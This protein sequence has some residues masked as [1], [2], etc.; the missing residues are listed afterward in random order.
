M[1][2]DNNSGRVPNHTGTVGGIL[3]KVQQAWGPGPL[4]NAKLNGPVPDR[5]FLYPSYPRTADPQIAKNLT[6]GRLM[7]GS[8]VI[9]SPDGAAGLWGRLY[10]D[11]KL[12]SYLHGFEWLQSFAV[13][14]QELVL[15]GDDKALA[16]N[17]QTIRGLTTE[18]LDRNEKWSPEIW[19][20]R[21]IAE[22][23]LHLCSQGSLIL[24]DSD[25]MWRSR[26]LTSMAR[27]ARYLAQCANK[28]NPGIDALLTAM[29]LCLAGLCLPG[30]EVALER[31]QELV[32]RELRL[33]LRSDGGHISRNPSIQLEIVLRL[34]MIAECY[35]HRKLPLPGHVR[36]A[37]G[38]AAAMVEF[39][40][41]PDG[42][43]MVFNGGYEDDSKA[44]IAAS[45]QIQQDSHPLGFAQ[46]TQYQR[47]NA[48]RAILLADVGSN[49]AVSKADAQIGDAFESAGSFHFSSGRTRI[50]SN[51][52]NGDHLGGDWPKALR[53]AAAHSGLSFEGQT[54]NRLD[55][56]SGETTHQ[57]ME[58]VNGILL[59]ITRPFV[60]RG[61]GKRHPS[62]AY[63]NNQAA[64]NSALLVPGYTRR[65]YMSAGGDDFRGEDSMI[66]LPENLTGLWRIRFHLAPCV[67][68]SVAR[69]EQSVILAMDNQEGWR[70]RTNY[71]GVRLEKSVYC[72]LGGTP[73]TTEQIVIGP[74]I[75]SGAIPNKIGPDMGEPQNITIKWAFKRLDGI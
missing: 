9:D 54:L 15:Q 25:P 46:Y 68:A 62:Q 42:A 56:F 52:G 29:G 24:N 11:E 17:E 45:K 19:Q 37:L 51:C 58:E 32:R 47:I 10:L 59:E 66:G 57:R 69:D 72:G 5:L 70:F 55:L 65:L 6:S 73:Q 20:P 38:R 53:Q 8:S 2:S 4:Q 28:A 33:Q 23:L 75:A 7:I 1:K 31:G 43:L 21:L 40:R 61:G 60:V 22:R 71:G 30:C 48:A 64:L 16:L 14:K 26:V 41:C 44:I 12:F 67:K 50:V 74:E 18:W 27:Q 63:E 49:E 34:K 35:T 36:L 3:G 39:F 13:H